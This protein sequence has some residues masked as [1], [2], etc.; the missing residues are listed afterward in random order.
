M[1][2][3]NLVLSFMLFFV[4]M[5]GIRTMPASADQRLINRAFNSSPAITT[6]CMSPDME[7]IACARGDS[8]IFVWDVVPGR[9]VGEYDLIQYTS[10]DYS[11]MIT[12]LAFSPQSDSVIAMLSNGSLI[13]FSLRSKEKT[14]QY[15]PPIN[16]HYTFGQLFHCGQRVTM[17][18]SSGKIMIMDIPTKRYMDALSH[19][20]RLRAISI[21]QKGHLLATEDER[22]IVTL[23]D[24]QTH[25]KITSTK[26]LVY[27]SAASDFS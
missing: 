4:L 22:G 19:S 16:T 17:A 10:E 24:V 20:N 26:G 3:P 7:Y 9:L 11:T 25:H 5:V 18:A 23:L 14:Y 8:R 2:R 15:F 1:S 27:T 13:K 12:S 21:A 6:L